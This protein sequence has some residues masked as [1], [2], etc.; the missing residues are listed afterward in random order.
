MSFYIMGPL[1]GPVLG[2]LT[3][4]FVAEHLGY[5]WVFII[6]S[7]ISGAAS[8]YAFLLPLK[9]SYAGVLKKRLVE[10]SEKGG[11]ERVRLDG[12]SDGVEEKGEGDP[13]E[14]EKEK[15]VGKSEGDLEA[16]SRSASLSSPT[17][18]SAPTP[19]KYLVRYEHPPNQRRILSTKEVL[20]VNMTRPFVLFFKSF[21]LFVLALF[22]AM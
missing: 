18:S 10:R 19:K 9:E 21:I 6:T 15:K 4:G 12:G 8:V 16:G 22:M 3:G 1:L 7:I 11:V 17:P 14:K 13:A 20:M 2:P 5:K